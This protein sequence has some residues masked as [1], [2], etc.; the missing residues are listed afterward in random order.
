[1]RLCK[2]YSVMQDQSDSMITEERDFHARILQGAFSLLLNVFFFKFAH[3]IHLT[4]RQT[5]L[6]VTC[7]SW[8]VSLVVVGYGMLVSLSR[9]FHARCNS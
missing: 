8:S 6:D 7:M 5:L 2:L 4:P 9:Q 1:M 3:L